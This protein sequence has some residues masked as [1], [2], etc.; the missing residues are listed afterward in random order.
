MVV[1]RLARRCALKTCHACG[2]SACC[3]FL[4]M[5]GTC[6]SLVASKSDMNHFTE[7]W[8]RK[9]NHEL[10]MAS[11]DCVTCNA[12]RVSSLP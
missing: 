12:L 1:N 2:I 7:E 11:E 6:L 4:L 9:Y 10:M 5:L 8:E 3:T